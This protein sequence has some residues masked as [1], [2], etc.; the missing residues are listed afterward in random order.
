MPI[1]FAKMIGEKFIYRYCFF[2]FFS[3]KEKKDLQAEESVNDS[4]IQSSNDES[5]ENDENE[6]INENVNAQPPASAYSSSILN[7]LFAPRK[8]SNQIYDENDEIVDNEDQQ[9]A[10]YEDDSNYNYIRK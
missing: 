5:N 6:S 2:F 3:S 10:N 4:N 7:M 1:N 9:D 8:D